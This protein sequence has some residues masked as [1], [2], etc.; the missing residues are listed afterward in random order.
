MSPQTRETFDRARE[1]VGKAAYVA[2]G[3][4]MAAMKSLNARISEL[5]DAVNSSRKELSEDLAREMNDWIAEGENVIEKAIGRLRSSDALDEA[6]DTV[7]ATRKR[8]EAGIDSA[9]ERFDQVLDIV[10]PEEGLGVITG[11]GP[12]Y[13]D[14]LSK[15]GIAGVSDFLSRTAASEDIAQLAD[16]AGFSVETIESWRDQVDLSR[17]NGVGASYQMLLHR[18]GIW[19]LP[20]LANADAE[21]LTSNLD[22]IDMPDSPEQKPSITT[23]RKWIREAKKLS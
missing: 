16:K 1:S 2:V 12:N 13:A 7:R 5:R 6:R 3:A 19:T 20:Q 8:A 14:Q 9:A 15:V 23:V 4:P 18:A 21:G 22:Q 10:E 11:I 17:V